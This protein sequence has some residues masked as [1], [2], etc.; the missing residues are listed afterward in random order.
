MA[1]S[2]ELKKQPKRITVNG[3][4]V[5]NRSTD[6]IRQD[7]QDTTVATLRSGKKLPFKMYSMK[8]PGSVY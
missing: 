6:E 8:M 3:E 7:E 2:D 1:T 4:T 5:E